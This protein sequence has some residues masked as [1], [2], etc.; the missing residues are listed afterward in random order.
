MDRHFVNSPILS[1]GCGLALSGAALS[2]LGGRPLRG[3]PA[4]FALSVCLSLSGDAVFSGGLPFAAPSWTAVKST[5]F[6]AGAGSPM[7]WI[8]D[9]FSSLP[10]CGAPSIDGAGASLSL[11]ASLPAGAGCSAVGGVISFDASSI[12]GDSAL[13]GAG[14]SCTGGAALAGSTFP[15]S[16]GLSTLPASEIFFL[17]SA[18]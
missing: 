5:T 4:S 12:T 16:V 15:D 8:V 10:G 6:P 1:R 7:P 11:G 14:C 3:L 13:A 18:T 2:A 17:S 9:C